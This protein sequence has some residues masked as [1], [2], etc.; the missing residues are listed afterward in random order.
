MGALLR[1]FWTPALLSEELPGPDCTPVRVRLMGENF[2]AFRDTSGRVG[3]LDA[4]CPHRGAELFFGRNEAGGLRC[5]YHGWKFGVDGACLD[6]PTEPKDSPLKAEVCA[7]AFPVVERA[8]IVWAYVG[9]RDRRPP[10]PEIEYL[11]VPPDNV[12]ASKCLMRCNYLQA[13]EGSMDTAHLS[14][15]HRTF[16]DTSGQPDFLGVGAFMRYSDQDGVPKFF[17]KDAEYGLEIT[18]RRDADQNQYYWRVSQYLFPLGVLVATA[19]DSICRGNIFVPIDDH[20]CWWYRVRWLADRALKDSEIAGFTADALDYAELLPGTYTPRGNKENDYLIDRDD[21]RA[22]SFS[23]IRSAQLQDIAVQESQT[24]I[25]DRTREFLGTSDTAI[26]ACRR[27]LLQG[28]QALA[29][30]VEPSAAQAAAAY[31]VVAPAFLLPRDVPVEGAAER[32]LSQV[33]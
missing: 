21:Q 13:L 19:P 28:A 2:I 23:G 29:K 4:H 3:L 26:V 14:F 5:A 1:R 27:R 6:M 20:H 15:L 25:A 33:A 10:L 18:A 24:A 8:G 12:F 16:E 31:R 22:K 11:R 9:P 17:V 30:G 32:L 7:P